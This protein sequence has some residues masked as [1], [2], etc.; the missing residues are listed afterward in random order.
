MSQEIRRVV[1]DTETTGLY[2]NSGDRIVELACVELID[3]VRTG[4][5]FHIYL[6]PLREITAESYKIHGLSNEFLKDKPTFPKIVD[7]FLRFIGASQLIIHNAGFD[8][9]FLNA[10]LALCG[11]PEIPLARTIDTLIIARKKFPGSPASLDALCKRFNISLE[12]RDKHGALIDSELL[13]L[14]YIELMGGAQS[15]LS[16]N[17]SQ[18]LTDSYNKTMQINRSFR[19]A[20]NFTVS[21]Q[22]LRSHREFLQK[23]KNPLWIKA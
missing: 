4:K 15:T 18:T 17:N 23:L 8:I 7:E 5:T 11:L 3:N 16:L 19:K 10:E 21:D 12:S 6:N 1:L 14:V 20:R 2:P 13:A 9:S 22:E